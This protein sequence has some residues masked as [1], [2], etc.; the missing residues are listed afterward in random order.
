MRICGRCR[1][2][3][4]K[5]ATSCPHCGAYF[6]PR[7]VALPSEPLPQQQPPMYGQP[8]MPQG[9]PVMTSEKSFVTLLLLCLFLGA[10][11]AH[12]FYA[13]RI[14]SA[15]ALLLLTIFSPCTF[16]I[17]LAVTS[18][19]SFVDL[20]VIICGKFTDGKG[21]TVKAQ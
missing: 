1:K 16:L 13:G 12:R 2:E 8:M 17:S 6:K 4:S 10:V 19:W 7:A 9:Q 11:G 21:L 18:I 15:I 20:I 14:G 5:E 3:V